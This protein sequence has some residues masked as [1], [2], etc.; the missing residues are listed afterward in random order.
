ML[1]RVVFCLAA[2]SLL[3]FGLSPAA[4]SAGGL[5][6]VEATIFVDDFSRVEI[7]AFPEGWESRGGDPKKVYRV[8]F[9]REKYLEAIAVNSAVVIAKKFEY[10]PE[11]YPFLA[12]DWRVRELPRGADE[13][14]KSSGDSAAAIYVIFPGRI[15]PRN[16]KYVWSS[17]LSPGTVTQSPYRTTTKI[18]VL[19]NHSAPMNHWVSEKVNIVEDYRRVFGDEPERVQAVA[20][21]SDSDNT[22]STAA[23]GYKGL[24]VSKF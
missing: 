21:M 6:S 22:E 18:I 9:D 2:C 4:F 7:G 17:S 11:D 12:W 14:Y 19:R 20:I 10:E 24:S 23:A 16:I 1:K 5:D 15:R 13:R 3:I 8:R